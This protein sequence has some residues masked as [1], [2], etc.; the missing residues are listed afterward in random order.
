M[1]LCEKAVWAS[2]VGAA[3]SSFVSDKWNYPDLHHC[4]IPGSVQKGLT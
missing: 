2:G 1:L 4:S 3:S